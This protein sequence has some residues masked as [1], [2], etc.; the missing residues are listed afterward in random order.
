MEFKHLFFSFFFFRFLSFLA[1]FFFFLDSF[2]DSSESEEESDELP[3]SLELLLELEEA[4]TF[5]LSPLFAEK[6]NYLLDEALTRSP[7]KY[8]KKMLCGQTF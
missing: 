4:C 6:L 2:S 5:F 8:K 3:D 7:K 1:F